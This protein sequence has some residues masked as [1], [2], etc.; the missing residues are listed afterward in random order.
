M[1]TKTPEMTR[2]VAERLALSPPSLA[3]S[4]LLGFD[5]TM[6]NAPAHQVGRGV[7]YGAGFRLSTRAF[8]QMTQD[9]CEVTNRDNVRVEL[10]VEAGPKGLQ[11]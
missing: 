7:W 11:A 10:D 6:Q 1:N 2:T 5:R 4:G 9:S 8:R 3:K